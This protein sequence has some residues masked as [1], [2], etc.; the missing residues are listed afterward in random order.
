MVRKVF[1]PLSQRLADTLE[2]P[3]V[4]AMRTRLGGRIAVAPPASLLPGSVVVLPTASGTERLGVMVACDERTAHV[5]LER[6][7]VKRTSTDSITPFS[8]DVPADLAI[9]A[10]QVRIFASLVE[11]Q[12][13]LVER[14]DKGTQP[15]IL[16]EKCRYGALVEVEGSKML[17]V[18]FGKLWPSAGAGQSGGTGAN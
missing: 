5:Y 15:G 14:E 13:V 11:G 6:G 16:R 3:T 17:G 9:I 12:D 10:R 8:G 7:I 4:D 1:L 2:T 18:G